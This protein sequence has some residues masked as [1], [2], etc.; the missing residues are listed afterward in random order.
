MEKL[1]LVSADGHAT[2][3]TTLWDDYLDPKFH[4]YLPRLREEQE[5]YNK[6]MVLLTE[7]NLAGRSS[8]LE[9]AYEEFDP[10]R[11]YRSGGWSGVWE[12][13]TRLKE[14]DREG[15]AAEFV[16]HGDFRA[17]DLFYSASN[18]NYDPPV[19]QAGANAFN[20]WLHDT[21]GAH[22]DRLLLIGAVGRAVNR[23]AIM[24]SFEWIADHGFAGSYMP[25]FTKHPD[26][27]PLDDEWWDPVWSLCEE[28]GLTMVVHGGYG[29][30]PGRMLGLSLIHIS[31][32]TRPY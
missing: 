29:L 16:F 22:Q 9:V 1:L 5:I 4:D 7:A 20:H 11:V 6:A 25:G 12:A 21:F 24:S 18:A 32:P 8:S 2:M 28:R 26:Q 23:D 14:M 30:L 3:P 15:V 17:G 31:E 27:L 10:D 13:E 19:A